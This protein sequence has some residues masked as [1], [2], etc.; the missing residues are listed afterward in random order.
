MPQPAKL[1]KA[2][3]HEVDL[4]NETAEPKLILGNPELRLT[5]RFDAGQVFRGIP[6]CLPG[7]VTGE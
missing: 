7:C 5:G 3:L 4:Q 1:T 2:E 6:E